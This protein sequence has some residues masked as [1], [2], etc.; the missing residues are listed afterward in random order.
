V[1]KNLIAARTAIYHRWSCKFHVDG[2]PTAR[3][4]FWC[5]VSRYCHNL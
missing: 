2:L 1:Q 5:L 4:C 3:P